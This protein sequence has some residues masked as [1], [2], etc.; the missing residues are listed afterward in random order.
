[1][2]DSKSL[3][4]LSDGPVKDILRPDYYVRAEPQIRFGPEKMN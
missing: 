1:M 3:D 4:I 2:S